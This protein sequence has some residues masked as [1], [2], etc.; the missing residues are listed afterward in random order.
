MHF[1]V[2]AVVVEALHLRG[3]SSFGRQM[4][5]R[6]LFVIL[7]LVMAMLVFVVVLAPAALTIALVIIVLILLL[8]KTSSHLQLLELDL[9]L[10]I[11]SAPTSLLEPLLYL[12]IPWLWLP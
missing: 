11:S 2:V 3:P 5:M 1:E 9:S 8:L 7:K 6:A 10:L 12:L 4:T